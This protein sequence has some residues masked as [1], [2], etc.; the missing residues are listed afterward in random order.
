MS[1]FVP[2]GSEPMDIEGEA[3]CDVDVQLV[4]TEGEQGASGNIKGTSVHIEDNSILDSDEGELSD[5]QD[6]GRA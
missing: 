4:M 3:G 6:Q 5:K 2:L 1:D